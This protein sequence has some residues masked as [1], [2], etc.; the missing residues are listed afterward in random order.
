MGC[1]HA[2]SW[3]SAKNYGHDATMRGFRTER[4]VSTSPHT[5]ER[6]LDAR[7]GESRSSRS[8]DNFRTLCPIPNR[9][10][11]AL[12]ASVR[13]FTDS[14][15]CRLIRFANPRT[16]SKGFDVINGHVSRAKSSSAGRTIGRSVDAACRCRW[17]SCQ[18]L[19]IRMLSVASILSRPARFDNARW[20]MASR[21]ASCG[22]S[23]A[24]V[25]CGDCPAAS[26]SRLRS[27][28]RRWR[29]AFDKAT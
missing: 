4:H 14:A 17:P 16:G 12:A 18:I 6:D 26:R 28:Y 2:W 5:A 10:P 21:M 29:S 19:M 22:R 1:D 23:A 20:P 11:C 3:P 8:P 7:V 13:P 25:A 27:R 15:R 9:P 24:M